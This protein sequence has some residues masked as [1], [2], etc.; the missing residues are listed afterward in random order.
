M[1]KLFF[2]LVL[3]SS[4]IVYRPFALADE[5]VRNLQVDLKAKG[6]TQ[7]EWVD[8]LQSNNIIFAPNDKFQ[9]RLTV[10]NLGNRNQTQIKV[11]QTLPANV[12]TD[13][14]T[15]FT[16]SQIAP[17]Q[18]WVKEITVTVKDRQYVYNYLANSTI[19]FDAISEIGTK[20]GDYTAFY[21]NMGTKPSES[22]T[23]ASTTKGGLPDTGST[24]TLIF[25]SA[26]AAAIGFVS[27]KLRRFARGY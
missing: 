21:T 15:E 11:T 25:G 14:P 8:N 27:L 1:K 22:A 16:L 6:F 17:D 2:V 19:R 12:T 5:E 13:S 7:T 9:I 24:S 18:D 10:K 4:F 3:L 20:A 23:S 26:I